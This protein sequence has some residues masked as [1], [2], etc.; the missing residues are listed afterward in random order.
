MSDRQRLVYIAMVARCS[1]VRYHQA[2]AR[3][4]LVDAS[5]AL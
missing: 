2:T 3:S 1:T 5:A 4:F